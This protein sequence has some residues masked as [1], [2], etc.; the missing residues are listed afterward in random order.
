VY[1]VTAIGASGDPSS[2][3]PTFA[4][5]STSY[6]EVPNS[7][8]VVPP[9]PGQRWLLLV[10]ASLQSTSLDYSAAEARYLVDGV[11]RGAGG[12]ESIEVGRPGPWQHMYMFDGTA[13]P[14]RIAFEL[15]DN[16]G[17]TTTLDH[18]RAVVVPIP[19]T[20]DP[21]FASNDAPPPVTSM[22]LN[23][24][25]E[26]V[27]T[28][29]TPGEYLV[30][31]LVNASEAPGTA[32][33]VTQWLD[34]V[35]TPWSRSFKNPRGALQTYLIVRRT[36]LSGPTTLVLQAS[37]GATSTIKYARVVALRVDALTGFDES[38]DVTTQ[39]TS[40]ATALTVNTLTPSSSLTADRYLVLGT[41]RVEDDCGNTQLAARGIQFDVD[42]TVQAYEHTSGNCATEMTYGYL[43]LHEA[44]PTTVAAS[45]SS[46]HAANEIVLHRES[47]LFILGVP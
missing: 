6:V 23:S 14:Q 17:A 3:P 33:I 19:A 12:T 13:L 8:I 18:L 47:T 32:D 9:S 36:V 44:R 40:L 7:T 26:V 24:A 2:T 43:G 45:I 20:A 39:M 15:H 29:S 4:T 5:T 34:P 25:A 42:G 30:L 37:T 31:L 35:G 1:E 11:E 27:V 28:P 16:L 22:T 38:S 21:Q 46:G 10:S 41:A